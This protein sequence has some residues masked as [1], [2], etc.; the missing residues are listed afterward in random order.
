MYYKIYLL[1]ILIGMLLWSCENESIPP[2]DTRLG[3]DYY[4]LEAGSYYVYDVQH[5]R[6]IFGRDPDTLRYQLKEAVV[7][8]FMGQSGEVIYQLER[9]SK[10]SPESI[11][12]LD[13]IWTARKNASRV[14]IAENNVPYVKLVF[15]F[16]LGLKWDGNALNSRAEQIYTLTSTSDE[17]KSGVAGHSPLD[18]LLSGSLTVIQ[19]Q[20]EDRIITDI[21]K[22]ETY[23]EG[24]G[25]FYKKSLN[26]HYCASDASCVGLGIIESGHDYQQILMEYGKALP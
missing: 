16:K 5:I 18:S 22:L 1:Y 13:S 3:L 2:Q 4:P 14:V 8:S 17:V 20:S 24:I 9:Y 21:R 10:A 6:Y 12:H 15:P 26:L 25:L 23:V 19:E 7:D 11:W